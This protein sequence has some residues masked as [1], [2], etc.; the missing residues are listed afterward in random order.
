LAIVFEEIGAY[1]AK[2]NK[3]VERKQAGDDYKFGLKQGFVEEFSFGD[4]DYND[5]F[6]RPDITEGRPIT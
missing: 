2:E 4:D 6:D 1:Q 5:Y 3:K